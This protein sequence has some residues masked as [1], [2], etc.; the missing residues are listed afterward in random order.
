MNNSNLYQIKKNFVF[1]HQKDENKPFKCKI[2]GTKYKGKVKF[3]HYMVYALLRGRAVEKCTHNHASSNYLLNLKLIKDLI[4]NYKE[5]PKTS[6]F[7]WILVPFI[8]EGIGRDELMC[9]LC[10]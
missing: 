10:G 1:F 8:G 5:R 9:I 4:D 7:D 6:T 3:I 2:Y